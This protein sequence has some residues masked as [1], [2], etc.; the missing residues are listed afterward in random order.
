[1]SSPNSEDSAERREFEIAK[2]YTETRQGPLLRHR[3]VAARAKILLIL[4]IIMAPMAYSAIMPLL[5]RD[6]DAAWF[7]AWIAATGGVAK[8]ATFML[9][10]LAAGSRSIYGDNPQA[11]ADFLHF[12]GIDFLCVLAVCFVMFGLSTTIR[13]VP[14]IGSAQ[15]GC[16]D[17]FA[18]G[19]PIGRGYKP[20]QV[21]G[22]FG[23][24]IS[25]L[26]QA[27]LILGALY[28]FIFKPAMTDGET[29]RDAH[30]HCAETQG[31]G[32]Y[33]HCVRYDTNSLDE[34]VWKLGWM[35]SLAAII[36]PL[37]LWYGLVNLTY[38]V[39][40]ALGQPRRS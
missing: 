37:G 34:T 26:L 3:L 4:S 9:P 36:V 18:K 30:H 38:P 24:L 23:G 14:K 33:S 27:A 5:S 20:K 40:L 22:T 25:T 17:Y 6:L 12:A 16:L 35:S 11:L 28:A 15:L 10:G 19:F 39:W 21:G 1:M 32:K 13:F 7:Q 31:V 2:A 29:F 8:F